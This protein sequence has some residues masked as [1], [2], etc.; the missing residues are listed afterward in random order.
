M[1]LQLILWDTKI[2][3]GLQLGPW[4]TDLDQLTTGYWQVFSKIALNLVL[5]WGL[6]YPNWIPK[7]SIKAFLSMDRCK[8]I[9]VQRTYYVANLLTFRSSLIS[10]RNIL[11]LS[12]IKSCAYPQFIQK[13]FILVVFYLNSQ[14]LVSN[15]DTCDLYHY[16]DV[17]VRNISKLFSSYN[18]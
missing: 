14:I 2:F 1:S 18:F 11:Q 13:Y 17:L 8:I 4:S 12:V 3:L 15:I 7:F 10:I 9:V 5:H 6:Q 16:N